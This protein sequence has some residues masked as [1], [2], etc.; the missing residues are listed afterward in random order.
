MQFIPN[1]HLQG[2]DDPHLPLAAH[3]IQGISHG[4]LL[5]TGADGL[6]AVYRFHFVTS[7]PFGHFIVHI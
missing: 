6:T 1:R 2:T 5:I 4:T 7:L 3:K